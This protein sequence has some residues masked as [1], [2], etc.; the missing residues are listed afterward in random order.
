MATVSLSGACLIPLLDCLE[1][2]TAGQSEQTDAYLTIVKYVSILFQLFTVFIQTANIKSCEI[3]Q[4]IMYLVRM[5]F[6]LDHLVIK[7]GWGGDFNLGLHKSDLL[8][9]SVIYGV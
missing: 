3:V 7:R 2:A 6:L 8:S 5:K 9:L 4:S 1:D